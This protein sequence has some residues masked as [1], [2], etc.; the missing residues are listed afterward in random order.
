[1]TIH[2]IKLD[3]YFKENNKSFLGTELFKVLEMFDIHPKDG[4]Y[5]AGG[6]VRKTVSGKDLFENNGDIDFFFKNRTAYRNFYNKLKTS[7]RFHVCIKHTPHVK[8]F[9]MLMGDPIPTVTPSV[10]FQF[11]EPLNYWQVGQDRYK[12]DTASIQLIH[13]RYF[14]S[15]EELLSNFD[16]TVCQF[17]ISKGKF[18]YGEKS[19][20]DNLFNKL[21]FNS[22]L[23]KRAIVYKRW[24]KYVNA[25]FKP[26]PQAQK[27]FQEIE[28][29][30]RENPGIT[31]PSLN[32]YT[33]V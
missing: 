2:S 23:N 4:V 18:Y 32:D 10:T 9:V 3:D 33:N 28:Q 21:N 13:F 29:W 14:D 31:D 25:G 15:M 5:L 17:G 27:T 12:K 20:G 30:T 7:K 11:E 19:L 6:A 16:F 24:W 1:M 8:N 22:T 26:T